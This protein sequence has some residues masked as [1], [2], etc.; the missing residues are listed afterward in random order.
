MLEALEGYGEHWE[1]QGAFG[2]Y[3]WIPWE[4]IRSIGRIMGSLGV[5]AD[6]GKSY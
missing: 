5:V 4:V 6:I 3:C 1:V 2:G